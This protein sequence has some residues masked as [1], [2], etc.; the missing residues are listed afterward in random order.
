[1]K[2]ENKKIFITG[3][4]RGIGLALAKQLAQKD[5][6]VIIG[7]RKQSVL[8]ELNKT[9]PQL[10]TLLFDA[11]DNE[12]LQNTF[13]FLQ[14]EVGSLDVLINN[15]AVLYSGNFEKDTFDFEQIEREVATNVS[16]P[17]KLTKLLLPLLEKQVHHRLSI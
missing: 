12:S 3:A 4:T 10:K 14:K 17:I 16:A 13:D 7:G 1:M 11:L 6:V 9:E 5:N 8:D 2:L 15:A